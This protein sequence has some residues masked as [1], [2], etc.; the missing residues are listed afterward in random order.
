MWLSSVPS[1]PGIKWLTGLDQMS[2]CDL[3]Q[4]TQSSRSISSLGTSKVVT[5]ISRT[6]RHPLCH[7]AAYNDSG[8]LIMIIKNSSRFL[9][10]LRKVIFLPLTWK[11]C[12]VDCI[13]S[14]YINWFLLGAITTYSDRRSIYKFIT[15]DRSIYKHTFSPSAP[16]KRR[17]T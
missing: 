5:Y 10:I 13:C 7:R 14:L 12:S 3:W 16:G 15:E 4:I 9:R 17:C 8:Q 11:K 6:L 1:S 2:R